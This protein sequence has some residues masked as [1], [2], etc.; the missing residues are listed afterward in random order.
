[1][2]LQSCFLLRFYKGIHLVFPCGQSLSRRTGGACRKAA[3]GAPE[4]RAQP[5]CPLTVW[6]GTPQSRLGNAGKWK[7]ATEEGEGRPLLLPSVVV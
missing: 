7:K 6:T 3:L 5:H 2:V 4:S 1:M